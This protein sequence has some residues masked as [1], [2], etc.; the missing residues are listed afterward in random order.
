[1]LFRSLATLV[2]PQGQLTVSEEEFG[3]AIQKVRLD[4]TNL[5]RWFIG[6]A[7][8]RERRAVLV[9]LQVVGAGAD[10]VQTF[11]P[12]VVEAARLTAGCF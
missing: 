9:N 8:L 3:Q 4:P 12:I 5:A 11:V 6:Q 2:H 10:Q 7:K 1:M